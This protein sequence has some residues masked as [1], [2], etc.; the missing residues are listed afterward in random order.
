MFRTIV[1][2]L[3]TLL[4]LQTPAVTKD[5]P[6]EPYT[7]ADAY[8]VYSA[9]IPSEWPLRV[10]KAKALV[11]QSQTRA[12]EMCLT[13]DQGSAEVVGGAISDYNSQNEKVWQLQK[14]FNLEVPYQIIA[15]DH[16]KAAFERGGWDGF[17]K[18]YPDSG[19]LI[20]LSAV[21]FNPERTVAVVYM[22]HS[23]GM[24]CGGGGFHVLQKKDGRWV[25][26]EW[27]GSS[28]YWA[29]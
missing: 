28:C 9:I 27:K 11:I 5:G 19:G 14:K 29:S 18:E 4:L 26:L 15:P 20:E 17:Y 21:G 23:C 16:F 7:D 25:P 10:A 3:V 12:Y 13:P 1:F 8:E 6:G 24:L 2:P 22:G